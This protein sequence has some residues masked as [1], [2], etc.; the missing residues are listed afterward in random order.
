MLLFTFQCQ[1]IMHR[2]HYHL[3][4]KV[5]YK[6]SLCEHYKQK[7]WF[8]HASDYVRLTIMVLI[9]MCNIMVLALGLGKNDT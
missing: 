8:I 4:L 2:T 6:H 7:L 5:K 3:N 1:T 9:F